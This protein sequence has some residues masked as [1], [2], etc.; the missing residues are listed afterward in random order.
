MSLSQK[1]SKLKIVPTTTTTT[2][3]TPT[4][5]STVPWSGLRRRQKANL[6]TIFVCE[7]DVC[8][9]YFYLHEILVPVL[10]QPVA[11]VLPLHPNHLRVGEQ[12]AKHINSVEHT[13]FPQL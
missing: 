7:T 4:T 11:G 8:V 12:P 9:Y 13:S 3:T 10:V 1:K 2:A 6:A 5:T